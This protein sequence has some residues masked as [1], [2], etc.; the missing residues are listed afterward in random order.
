MERD[1]G[2][3]IT[4]SQFLQLSCIT[5]AV[6]CMSYHLFTDSFDPLDT[7]LKNYKGRHRVD[8]GFMVVQRQCQCRKDLGKQ[9][10][11]RSPDTVNGA[12]CDD[13]KL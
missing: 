8:I 11:T 5:M 6:E 4:R 2:P 1:G 3:D 12:E 9:G 7:D 10:R 13:T